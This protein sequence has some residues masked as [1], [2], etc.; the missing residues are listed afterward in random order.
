MKMGLLFLTCADQAE[1]EKIAKLLLE[2]RLVACV[3]TMPVSSQFLW[4]RTVDRSQEVLLIMD[5]LMHKFDQIEQEIRTLHSYKTFV[6]TAIEIAK[7][8]TGV[9]DWITENIN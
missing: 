6:L 5:S 1:A 9:E 3:K 4:Q 2:K 8:S 7:A